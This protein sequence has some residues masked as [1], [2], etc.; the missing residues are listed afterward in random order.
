M[1]TQNEDTS[2]DKH[3]RFAQAL[4]KHLIETDFF[5]EMARQGITLDD[6]GET[7]E[8]DDEGDDTGAP[9]KPS[10]PDASADGGERTSTAAKRQAPGFAGRGGAR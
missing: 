10:R 1:G 3:E 9:A 5:G 6:G 4:A 7:E 2:T 8:R